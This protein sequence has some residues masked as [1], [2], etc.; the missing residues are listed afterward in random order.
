[1]SEFV[2]K[3]IV[4]DLYRVLRSL[5]QELPFWIVVAHLA[6]RAAGT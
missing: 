4:I 3:V 2:G 6:D 5:G 1:M